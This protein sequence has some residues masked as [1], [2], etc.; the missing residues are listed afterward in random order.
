MADGAS[1]VSKLPVLVD[2]VGSFQSL[3]LAVQKAIATIPTVYRTK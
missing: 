1:E 2:S 3:A